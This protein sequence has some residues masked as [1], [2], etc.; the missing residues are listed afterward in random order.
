MKLDDESRQLHQVLVGMWK[1]QPKDVHASLQWQ[2]SSK[3][4]PLI[5]KCQS[6]YRQYIVALL[7]RAYSDIHLHNLSDMIGLS[8]DEAKAFVLEHEW[9][10]SGD[11]MIT[12][13]SRQPTEDPSN[14]NQIT[15]QALF[16][17]LQ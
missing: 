1:R 9:T 15:K 3:L 16:F 11:Y 13:K 2:W 8:E 4:L 12:S 6:N 5:T 14:L 7:S 10:V 17:E